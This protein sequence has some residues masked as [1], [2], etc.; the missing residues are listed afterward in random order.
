[1]RI[2]VRFCDIDMVWKGWKLSNTHKKVLNAQA[3]DKAAL[4]QQ[5]AGVNPGKIF[6]ILIRCESY[7][8][9]MRRCWMLRLLVKLPWHN[10]LLV[11]IQVS[12]NLKYLI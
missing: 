12:H 5:V 6:T 7:L 1:M 3:A 2:Q 10:R 11:R 8:I 4:A 9:H